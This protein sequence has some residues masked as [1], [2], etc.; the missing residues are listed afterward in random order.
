MC[1]AAPDN[2]QLDLHLWH[3]KFAGRP[4]DAEK[5]GRRKQKTDSR[6]KP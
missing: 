6:T 1:A 3:G 4:K 5:K 2:V